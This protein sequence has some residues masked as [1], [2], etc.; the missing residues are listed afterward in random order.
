MGPSCPG[1]KPTTSEPGLLSRV[2]HAALLH[3]TRTLQGS[4]RFSFRYAHSVTP[5]LWI[6]VG[7]FKI[8]LKSN[9]CSGGNGATAVLRP[10][11]FCL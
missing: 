9:V 5:I 3:Y 10:Q 4:D 1:I 2:A 8:C 7:L 6:P 11:H